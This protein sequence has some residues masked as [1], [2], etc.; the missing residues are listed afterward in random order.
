L[1]RRLRGKWRGRNERSR[2]WRH[3][4]GWDDEIRW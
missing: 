4:N 2:G 1:R 3:E